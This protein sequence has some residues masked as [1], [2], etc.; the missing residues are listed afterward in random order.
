MAVVKPFRGLRYNP[1]KI[2][3][4]EDIVTPPYDVIDEQGTDFY[5]KNPYNMI[6]LDLTKFAGNDVTE[7]RYLSAKRKFDRWQDE[8]VLIQD[9][10]P[11]LYLYFIDYTL[12][13]GKKFTRKGFVGTVGLAEFSEGIV[14]PHEMTFRSVTTDRLRLLDTCRAQFSQVFSFFSDEQGEVMAALEKGCPDTPLYS[15]EDQDGS[16]HRL[17]RITDPEIFAHVQSFFQDKSLYIADGHHRYT[18]ALQLRELLWER[19][20]TLEVDSPFNHI[21]MYLCPMEDPG[22][23]VLPTHRLVSYPEKL[24][25]SDLIAKLRSSFHIEEIKNGSR[26]MLVV[27]VI[28][29]MDEHKSGDRT[30]FG[31]YHPREDRC[32][33]LTLKDGAM[34]NIKADLAD[35]LRELDVVALSELVLDRL[36]GL[37]HERCEK[38]DLVH[39]Y[40]D[41]DNA[42]DVA[43]K[44]ATGTDQEPILFLMNNTPVFQVKKIADQNL[45]MPHKSTYF[46]PK[47]LTGLLI[48]K[49]DE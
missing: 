17:W 11:A 13:S 4:M 18:T 5:K 35:A 31:L 26:E 14:K 23:T 42:L 25:V 7:E 47:I 28:G 34:V 30:V 48:N 32:L 20:E 44:G 9:Q 2:E 24:S 49:L 22:L 3:R 41:P 43:V 39:Y 40:S 36:L 8:S 10:F 15:V 45:I 33:M 12:P 29:R 46:Y 21:I 38:E 19:G 27:E 37:D 1:E 16:V 6:Q